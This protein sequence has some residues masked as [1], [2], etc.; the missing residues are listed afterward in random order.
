[1]ARLERILIA[2]GGIA[3]VT[4]AIALRRRGFN[5][6]VIEKSDRWGVVGA[7]IALQPNAM[8]ALAELGV[9]ATIDRVGARL[10]W[11][12]YYGLPQ[13]EALC[14]IDLVQFWKNVGPFVGVGR[15]K[16][17]A[18]LL[19]SLADTP[20]RLGAWITS[21]SQRDRRVSVG[22]NDGSFGEYDL[23]IGADGIRSS[24]RSLAMS[25]AA[26]S[27]CGQIGWRSLAAVAH[28]SLDEL[29][30]WLGEGH[31]FGLFPV[32]D[33]QMYGFGY[34][35]EPIRCHDPEAGRLGRLRDRFAGFGGAVAAYL[36]ALEHDEQI[37]CAP[38][39]SLQLT[40]WRQGRV[41]LIGDAAHASSPLMGQGG[42]MAIEDGAVLAELLASSDSAEAALDGYERR[43]RPRVDWVQAQSVAA[44]Q[45]A[46]LPA[47]VRDPILR[48]R[49][50]QAFYDRYM[51]LLA[52]P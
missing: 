17:Q 52:E 45:V 1:M 24:V 16:L 49:G 31:L 42:C 5:P 9:G 25:D 33:E 35:L 22:F 15:A 26:P 27:Y 12:R 14:E 4:A 34:C 43:R 32:N 10:R 51:P 18:S 8:R 2:G 23:V 47:S 30:L 29:Q 48:D 37:H 41:V 6:E 11:V 21:L 50:A 40:C 36:A 19:H 20:C 28:E 38:I 13:G 46:L 39:E 3:G 44:G 7:G